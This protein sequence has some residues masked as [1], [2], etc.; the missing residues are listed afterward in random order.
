VESP[1]ELGE[2]LGAL[3]GNYY[4]IDMSLEQMI[5]FRPLPELA[6]Y[7]T[8]IKGLFLTGAGTHP[9]GSISGMPGRNCARA[10][11]YTQ[12]PV[13]QALKDAGNSFKSTVQSVFG[14]S[15]V[16]GRKKNSNKP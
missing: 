7:S 1:A 11:L 10:F 9:G 12:Q 5:F 14:L 2:R 4:H 16:Q 15:S 3:K 8:P 13:T 6:N